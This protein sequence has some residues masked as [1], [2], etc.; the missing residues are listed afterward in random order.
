KL[1]PY[2]AGKKDIGEEKTHLKKHAYSD[3][4]YV[5]FVIIAFLFAACF[6]QLFTIQP[7]FFKTEWHFNEAFI[8]MLLALNGIIIVV[9]EMIVVYSIERKKLNTFFIRT[10]YL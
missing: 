10:G 1:L 9:V 8:G 5:A 4:Y 6:F 7:V 2:A 3:A